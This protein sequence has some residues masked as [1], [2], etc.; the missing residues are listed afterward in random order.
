M[1]EWCSSCGAW[2]VFLE[3]G[4][5][6]SYCVGYCVGVSGEVVDNGWRAGG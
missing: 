2:G 3:A 5:F 4:M 1:R 6:A